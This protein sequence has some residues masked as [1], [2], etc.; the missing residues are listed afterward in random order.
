MRGGIGGRVHQAKRS[1]G[2]T[3]YDIRVPV[4]PELSP[5]GLSQADYSVCIARDSID[6]RH[7]PVTLEAHDKSAAEA[8]RKLRIFIPDDCLFDV[9]GPTRLKYS[10]GPRLGIRLGV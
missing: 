1:L 3:R 6:S 7:S 2:K 5:T 10:V 9:L 8:A 4:S